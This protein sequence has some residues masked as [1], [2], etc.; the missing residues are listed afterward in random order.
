M[1]GLELT[2]RLLRRTDRTVKRT[3]DLALILLGSIVVLPLSLLI[4]LS[5]KLDPHGPVI[6]SQTRLGRNGKLF[7]ALK[8]RSMIKNADEILHDYLSQHPEL[9]K[10]WQATQKPKK[11]PRITKLGKLLRCTSLDE[12][13]QLLNVLRGEMSLVGPRPILRT[14]SSATVGCGLSTSAYAPASRASGRFPAATTPATMYA[15]GR[16]SLDVYILART[17]MVVLKRD[18][19]Y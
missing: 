7:P 11:D 17:F 13:P 4:A 6:Y 5:I 8:F 18:G 14:R 2:H 12:L 15:T 3:M 9:K 16:C 1:L 19:A 10:E